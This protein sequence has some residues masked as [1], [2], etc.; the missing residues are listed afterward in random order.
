M[1][2][3]T[4]DLVLIPGTLCDARLFERQRRDLRRLV[5]GLRVTVVD[6]HGFSLDDPAAAEASIEAWSQAWMQRLPPHFALAGF[7]LGGLIALQWLRSH[8]QREQALA[9]VASNAEAGSRRA[10]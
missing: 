7:S 9:R 2:A 6:L 10:P 5:P 8:P 1:S 4:R 3:S